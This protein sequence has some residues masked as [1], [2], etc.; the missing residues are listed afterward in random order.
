M[1]PQVVKET[2]DTSG[3]DCVSNGITCFK[4]CWLGISAPGMKYYKE[5]FYWL[6]LHKMEQSGLLLTSI[7][8]VLVSF[9]KSIK[10]ILQMPHIWK[11]S[12]VTS[13]SLKTLNETV[14]AHCTMHWTQKPMWI[15]I[16]AKVDCVL[17]ASFTKTCTCDPRE[18][19]KYLCDWVISWVDQFISSVELFIGANYGWTTSA[20]L[21]CSKKN[22]RHLVPNCRWIES[23][24]S[25][26]SN[27]VKWSLVILINRSCTKLVW[28]CK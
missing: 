27:C 15:L 1:L 9:W 4:W 3:Y 14:A 28:S 6:W 2:E 11:I 26:L 7:T 19:T 20:N 16:T 22:S 17:R 18:N 10:S 25:H 5:L 24:I 12:T 13:V 21:L 23:G 8:K